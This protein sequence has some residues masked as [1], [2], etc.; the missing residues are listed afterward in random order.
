MGEALAANPELIEKSD[1]KCPFSAL[2]TPDENESPEAQAL[3]KGVTA[4]LSEQNKQTKQVLAAK[5]KP[6]SASVVV[7]NGDKPTS[8]V[9]TGPVDQVLNESGVM[10]ALDKKRQMLKDSF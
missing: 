1:G 9:Y 7:K 10:S 6:A 3:K 8:H 2:F 5:N 4:K